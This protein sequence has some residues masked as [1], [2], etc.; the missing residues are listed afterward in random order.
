MEKVQI[1]K[2]P[3]PMMP[4]DLSHGLSQNEPINWLFGRVLAKLADRGETHF[5]FQILAGGHE[6]TR[7]WWNAIIREFR[8]LLV[9][10]EVAAKKCDDEL[11]G[12]P[13]TRIADF[14]SE[15]F[16]VIH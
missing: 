15:V 8:S 3:T 12:S 14:M 9:D 10:P 2:M 6:Q 7:E 11:G 4:E 16:A 13:A 5:L 1:H